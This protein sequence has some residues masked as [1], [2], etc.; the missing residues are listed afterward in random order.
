LPVV[1]GQLSSPV[2]AGSQ[3]RP[4]ARP[5]GFESRQSAVRDPAVAG[6]PVV[7][8]DA[9]RHV[10]G[11]ALV[12]LLAVVIIVAASVSAVVVLAG[13]TR[14][15]RGASRVSS[16][17]AVFGQMMATN[18]TAAQLAA[19]A[20]ARSCQEASPGTSTRAVLLG[21]LGQAVAL[22]RSVLRALAID[23]AELATMPD[24]GLLITDIT[25]ATT[26][27][28]A[29]DQDDQGWLQDLQATGCYSAPTNDLHYREA[30]LAIP[31]ATAADRR[32]T[33]AWAKAGTR[34]KVGSA[35]IR[36]DR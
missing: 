18:T 33:V 31:V 29:V 11:R 34:A 9:G 24:G 23:R 20:V 15:G 2:N 8:G 32:L 7:L 36:A 6:A 27:A 21:D 14:G 10:P 25:A 13:G 22:R 17:E 19:T 26:A 16:A 28:L 3:A 4:D 1:G 30:A 35:P 5:G 12:W